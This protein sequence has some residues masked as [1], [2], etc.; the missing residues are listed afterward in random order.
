[1][2]VDLEQPLED[3]IV[4]MIDRWL[5]RMPGRLGDTGSQRS[6]PDHRRQRVGELLDGLDR[7]VIKAC[8]KESKVCNGV[9]L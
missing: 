6:L 1:M 9:G 4:A 3:S 7:A 8:V 2:R 5:H